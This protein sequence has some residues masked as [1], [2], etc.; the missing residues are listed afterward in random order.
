MTAAIP[1]A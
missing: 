1:F